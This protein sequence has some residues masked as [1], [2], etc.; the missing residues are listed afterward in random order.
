[1]S[2]QQ[3]LWGGRFTEPTDAF[4]ERFTASVEFDQKLARYDIQGSKAHATM[5]TQVGILTADENKKIQ[6]GLDEIW[7]E[8]ESGQ[9]DAP[10]A[11]MHT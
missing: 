1:M 5:L 8:I 11:C 9:F 2:D 3:K 10:Q 7:S 6:N 4:V